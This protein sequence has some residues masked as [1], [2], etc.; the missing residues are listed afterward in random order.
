MKNLM[1]EIPLREPA[2]AQREAS[3]ALAV[4]LWSKRTVTWDSTV[5]AT[6]VCDGVE[7]IKLGE[8]GLLSVEFQAK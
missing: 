8:F 4:A 2:E 7:K 5:S 1:D 3:K 6:I